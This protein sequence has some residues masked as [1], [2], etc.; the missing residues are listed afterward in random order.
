MPWTVSLWEQVQNNWG[1]DA[2]RCACT[3]N[4]ETASMPRWAVHVGLL[5]HL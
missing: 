3:S 2:A 4:L 5:P 1:C